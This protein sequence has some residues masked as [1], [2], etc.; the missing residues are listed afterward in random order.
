[1]ASYEALAAENAA[2]KA[3]VESLEET[4]AAISKL[5]DE[6]VRYAEEEGT[7]AKLAAIEKQTAEA[8]KNYEERMR[9]AIQAARKWGEANTSVGRKQ[10]LEFIERALP[11]Q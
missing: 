2:L 3:K 6:K 8:V 10:L 4:V 5:Y 11:R 1:M 7:R 9:W